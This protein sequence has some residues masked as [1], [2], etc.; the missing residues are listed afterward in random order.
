MLTLSIDGKTVSRAERYAK[1]RNRSL[2]KFVESYLQA[3]T[4]REAG[5]AERARLV[6]DRSGVVGAACAKDR[7]SNSAAHLAQKCR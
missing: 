7:R 5:E 1:A 2:S 3:V 6:A 4:E